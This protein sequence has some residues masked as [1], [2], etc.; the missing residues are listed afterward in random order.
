M[1]CV[2]FVGAHRAHKVRLLCSSAAARSGHHPAG[3]TYFV[4]GHQIVMLEL[5]IH[6]IESLVDA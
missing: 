4:M 5:V 3:R 1:P 6:M 2:D